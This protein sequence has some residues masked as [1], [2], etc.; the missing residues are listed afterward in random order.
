MDPL[1]TICPQLQMSLPALS[2]CRS[3][4]SVAV[5]SSI[6]VTKIYLPTLSSSS[7]SS[8]SSATLGRTF[9]CIN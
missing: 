2:L 8:S 3:C 1:S 4:G 7:S 5:P 9:N 6:Q